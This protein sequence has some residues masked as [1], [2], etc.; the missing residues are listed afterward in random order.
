MEE[1]RRFPTLRIVEVDGERYASL[2]MAQVLALGDVALA[3]AGVVRQALAR[4][5]GLSSAA[6]IRRLIRQ[7]ARQRGV[8]PPVANG[9]GGCTQEVA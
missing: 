5:D 2:E 6:V 9:S 3:V 4:E 8:W 7:E 1:V